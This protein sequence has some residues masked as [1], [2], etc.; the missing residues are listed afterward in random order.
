MP[1]KWFHAIA[2][3]GAA[4][5]VPA[6]VGSATADEGESQGR[7]SQ[8]TR[9]ERQRPSESQA[10]SEQQQGQSGSQASQQGQSQRA[11][12]QQGQSQQ[13]Q[14]GQPQGDDTFYGNYDGGFDAGFDEDDWFF[15]YYAYD[16]N[17]PTFEYW[18]NYDAQERSFEWEENG[19]FA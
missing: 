10:Q 2:L 8:E 1:K 19:L 5:L 12:S 15:D 3:A 16:A 11:Q 17:A 18:A 9:S 13:G 4:L 6:W 14:S 7:S